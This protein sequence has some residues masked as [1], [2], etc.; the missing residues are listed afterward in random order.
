MSHCEG[1]NERGEGQDDN[2]EVRMAA[3]FISLGPSFLKDERVLA[4]NGKCR[5]T[6]GSTY[7][8]DNQNAA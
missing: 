2:Y 5:T 8:T 4:F 3:L 6:K 1:F 7:F